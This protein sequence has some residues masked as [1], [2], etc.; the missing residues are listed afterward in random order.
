MSCQRERAGNAV[1]AHASL[2]FPGLWILELWACLGLGR[3]WCSCRRRIRRSSR[4][5]RS[6][7]S[8]G[9]V[10]LSTLSR[11]LAIAPQSL[12]NWVKQDQLTRRERDDG[13]TSAERD[14]LRELRRRVRRL[15]QEKEILRK[16]ASSSP[17][18]RSGERV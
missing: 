16:A 5:A 11:E 17:G 4:E 1:G 10:A 15:K 7:L 18:R 8:V 14:E 6:R 13:L 12:R 2:D 9:V 3:G